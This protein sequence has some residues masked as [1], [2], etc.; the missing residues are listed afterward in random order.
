MY[1]L[2]KQMMC[3]GPTRRASLYPSAN[4]MLQGLVL[5]CSGLQWS[6]LDVFPAAREASASSP[7][8]TPPVWLALDEVITMWIISLFD[9]R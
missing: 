7:T 9:T 8:A 6:S 1:M 3:G 4:A 5:D 2:V